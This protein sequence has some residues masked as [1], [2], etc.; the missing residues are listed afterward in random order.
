MELS[1]RLVVIKQHCCR[2]ERA[3]FDSAL[4]WRNYFQQ[5][6]KVCNN[7]QHF[8]VCH[9]TLK[10]A[11]ASIKHKHDISSQDFVFRCM[12]NLIF[13]S[14]FNLPY[15]NWICFSK[16]RQN[17]NY[18]QLKGHSDLKAPYLLIPNMCR[19]F[20]LAMTFFILQRQK[21]I[22]NKDQCTVIRPLVVI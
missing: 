6:R 15:F 18:K 8:S 2:L 21:K 3:L 16:T 19:F 13:N 9:R 5:L 7:N 20:L 12:I 11:R 4:F 22:N 17:A 1:R 14:K 10:K